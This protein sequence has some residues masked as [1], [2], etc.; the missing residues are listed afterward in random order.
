[1]E[2]TNAGS[3]GLFSRLQQQLAMRV[4]FGGGQHDAQSG[5][6]ERRDQSSMPPR[7]R[8]LEHHR[9]EAR[10]DDRHVRKPTAN[11]T[12]VAREAI[13]YERAERGT[14]KLRTQEGDIVQLNFLDNDS[15]KMRS[16]RFTDDDVVSRVLSLDVNSETRLEIAVKGDISA[17]EQT[18]IDEVL[19]QA[20]KIAASFYAGDVAEAF[21]FAS[22]FRID[23]E[24][25]A[26]VSMRASVQE[27]FSY[28]QQVVT[29]RLAPDPSVEPQLVA[30]AP[31][32]VRS[33]A[34]PE[35]VSLPDGAAVAQVDDDSR[36]TRT[37]P[38]RD[39]AAPEPAPA[40]VTDSPADFPAAVE[41]LAYALTT[42]AG[43]LNLLAEPH[44]VSDGQPETTP[45]QSD[46]FF[47]HG[48]K[49]QI[50]SAIVDATK[51]ADDESL[52]RG[53]ELAAATIDEL[54]AQ[55]DARLDEV[56]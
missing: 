41:R 45:M 3:S 50:V 48:F 29:S 47:S 42:I 38:A 32:S 9:T 55:S 44:E 13:G 19:A 49:L 17:E 40:Q 15:F 20:G 30:D 14:L 1:M 24:H 6:L 22:D 10:D 43:F 54:A 28:A 34:Q 23:S 53:V 18:A 21:T 56:V 37:A 51:P 12:T 33:T 31:E 5:A 4:R 39:V 7:G 26:R 36:I 46:F 35:N 25:L 27:R 52:A 8:N 11:A 2:L 16:E